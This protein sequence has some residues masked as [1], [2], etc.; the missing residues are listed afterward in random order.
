MLF[1]HGYQTLLLL[2][3]APGVRLV[4]A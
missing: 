4:V 3:Q 2:R 1:G